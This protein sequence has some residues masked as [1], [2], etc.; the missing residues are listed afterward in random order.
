MPRCAAC[1]STFPVIPLS[2]SS[3]PTSAFLSSSMC[4]RYMHGGGRMCFPRPRLPVSSSIASHVSS[5]LSVCS[6]ES[7][8]IGRP[9]RVFRPRLC[10]LGS[11][12]RS[13]RAAL[14][15]KAGGF[16][17]AALEG[18]A[19]LPS[20][21]VPRTVQRAPT[22]EPALQKKAKTF[23]VLVSWPACAAAFLVPGLWFSGPCPF[24]FL[25]AFVPP[26][27]SFYWPRASRSSSQRGRDVG[28]SSKRAPTQEPVQ[29][30]DP[31][32]AFIG[33]PLR[34]TLLCTSLRPCSP[35]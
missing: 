33:I 13:R 23:S 8:S 28:S 19:A 16:S 34:T 35:K 5:L 20:G 27:V 11:R 6:A 14:L 32:T 2:L 4:A 22:Q 17:S 21:A 15:C 25:F 10:A 3:G 30:A 12:L 31:R 29:G 1:G 9:G 7:F 24:G 26:D 18:S